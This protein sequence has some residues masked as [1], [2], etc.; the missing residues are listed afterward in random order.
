MISWIQFGLLVSIYQFSEKDCFTQVG[1]KKWDHRVIQEILVAGVTTQRKARLGDRIMTNHSKLGVVI[2]AI[3]LMALPLLAACSDDETEAPTAAKTETPA[4]TTTAGPGSTET[5]PPATSPS[6]PVEDVTITIGN[7]SDLTGVAAQAMQIVDAALEDIVSY[8]NEE[9]LIPGAKLKIETYDSQYDPSRDIPGYEWL[10]ERGAQVLIS[11]ISSAPVTL[12]DRLAEDEIVFLSMTQNEEM[13]D[14][15]GWVFCMSSPP[16]TMTLMKWIA[17]HDWDYEANGPA[18]IGAA[19]WAG[20]YEEPLH[21]AMEDYAKA[22][23]DQFEWEG[24]QMTNMG[25]TWGPEVEALKKC[26]YV[27]VPATGFVIGGFIRE[28]RNAGGTATFLGTDAQPAYLGMTLNQVGWEGIDGM[29]HI[30]PNRWTTEDYEVPNLVNELLQKYHDETEREVI[31]FA[32]LSY[33]GSFAMLYGCISVL[34]E[35]INTVG[36]QNWTPADL[37]DTCTSFSMAYGGCEEWNWSDTKRTAWNHLGIYEAS[38]EAE[39]FVRKDPNW[40]PILY[41]P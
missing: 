27:F 36:P 12:K 21:E 33:P 19:G 38:A 17:E 9:N 14:P 32:G 25:V 39:D 41:E 7:I 3:L 2:L 22:H 35:S 18:K 10:K 31:E 11:G 4:G 16:S 28:F 15:P 8:F 29:L 23:P 1:I 6:E 20:P 30:L 24:S 37:Y 13:I 40:Y 26:D 5:Q 34:A